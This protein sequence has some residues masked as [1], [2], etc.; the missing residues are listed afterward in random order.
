[1]KSLQDELNK[2][3]YDQIQELDNL[4]LKDPIFSIKYP[5]MH[6]F[7]LD[8]D[9]LASFSQSKPNEPSISLNILI[10]YFLLFRII[11][12]YRRFEISTINQIIEILL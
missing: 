4:D 8:L 6:K 11:L 7:L 5:K 12:P 9:E 2:V 3:D 1:M 10:L